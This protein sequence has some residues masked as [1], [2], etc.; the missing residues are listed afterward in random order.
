[1][2]AALT[3]DLVLDWCK[4]SVVIDR[5]MK[6]LLDYNILHIRGTPASGKSVLLA[7]IHDY[8]LNHYPSWSVI[9]IRSWPQHLSSSSPDDSRVFLEKILG[10]T[11]DQLPRLRQPIVLLIDE[12]Q[13]SKSDTFFWNDFLKFLV[14]PR[15]V[16]VYVIMC[17]AYGSAGR[18]PVD[19]PLITPPILNWVQRIELT[20]SGDTEYVPIG[21]YLSRD[22]T[23]DVFDRTTKY[24]QDHPRYS[25]ALRD[26]LFHLTNGHTGALTSIMEIINMEPVGNTL[27]SRSES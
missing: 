8:I 14:Q 24:H 4:R 7:L 19:L 10:T 20:W 3:T 25:E 12:A 9:S 23:T 16:P 18:F 15:T 26:Y 17:S 22:E 27:L 11:L 2:Y 21:L 6:R 5:L 13:T 1:M